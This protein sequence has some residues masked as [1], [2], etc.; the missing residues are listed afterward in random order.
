[1]LPGSGLGVVGGGVL[2]LVGAGIVVVLA[3][4]AFL[5]WLYRLGMDEGDEVES[6]EIWESEDQ[7]TGDLDDQTIDDES[8]A[9]HNPQA[10]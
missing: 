8:G 10:H 1:L 3:V 6:Q 9:I 4:G 7:A 5:F 2:C